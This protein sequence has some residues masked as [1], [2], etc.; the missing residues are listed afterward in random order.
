MAFTKVSTQIF[1]LAQKLVLVHTIKHT[2]THTHAHTNV[3]QTF[4][5]MWGHWA[6]KAKNYA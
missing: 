3:E 4:R 2:H 6:K 1:Q 5:R